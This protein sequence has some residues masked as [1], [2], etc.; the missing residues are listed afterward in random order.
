[1]LMEDNQDVLI[2]G[3]GRDKQLYKKVDHYIECVRTFPTSPT[4]KYNKKIYMFKKKCHTNI[5]KMFLNCPIKDIKRYNILRIL[6]FLHILL[7]VLC[8]AGWICVVI[9]FVP[10][11]DLRQKWIWICSIKTVGFLQKVWLDFFSLNFNL[12]Y[13]QM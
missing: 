2:W 1:M 9:E 11:Q 13:S 6:L 3:K 7:F 8:T 12:N 4:V 5:T 10:L